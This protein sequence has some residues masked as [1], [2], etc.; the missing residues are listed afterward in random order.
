[1]PDAGPRRR[2]AGPTLLAAARLALA[3][4][5]LAAC[6]S[7]TSVATASGT[8]RVSQSGSGK[9][10]SVTVHTKKGSVQF[11]VG[12]R[13]PAGF[14]SAVPLPSGAARTAAIAG[15]AKGQTG[16][17]L[18]Y[19]VRGSL[20]SL[21]RRYGHALAAAG[22]SLKAAVSTKGTVMQTW[23]VPVFDVTILASSSSGSSGPAELS[24]TVTSNAG[25]PGG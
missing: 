16:Y 21:L 24:L 6:S 20:S 14:P 19:R 8:V 7:R 2:R 12:A 3:A 10:L 25:A 9:N 4:P 13:L 15:A 5:G 18:I 23:D 1:M 11:G 22:F 17:E